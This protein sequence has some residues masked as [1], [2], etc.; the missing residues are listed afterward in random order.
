MGK[1]RK[2]RARRAG[3]GGKPVVAATVERWLQ[4]AAAAEQRGALGEARTYYR[5]VADKVPDHA[6]VWHALAGIC[7]Q[8][9]SPAEAIAALEQACGAEP[10]NSTYLS[11]LGGM[12]MAGGAL[13]EAERTLRAVMS[14]DPELSQARYNFATVLYQQGKIA[15]SITELNRLTRDEPGF[16]EAHFNLA[17][18]LRDIGNLSAALASF[19]AA[20]KLQPENPRVY[21]EIARLQNEAHIVVDAIKHYRRYMAMVD[22]DPVATAEL[23]ELLHRQGETEAAVALLGD[24]PSDG[25]S[26]EQTRLS[27]AGILHNAGQLKEAESVYLSVLGDYP[28][29]TSA[30][31]GLSRLRQFVDP[32]D[33]VILRLRAALNAPGMSETGAEPVHFALGKIYDDLGEYD[34][35]FEHYLRGNTT[36]AM[37][38]NY[39]RA[40]TESFTDDLIGIFSTSALTL[41][42]G[43]TSDSQK[44]VLIVGMP[45]SGTTLTEQIIAS[46]RDAAGAGELAF[47]QA[48]AKQLPELAGTDGAYP[49]CWA[50]VGD[51]TIAEI[52]GQYLGL[53]DRH[54]P[55]SARVTDKM[56]VNY[57]HVGLFHCLFPHARVVVC[58]RD[59]RD[60][61]LSIFF[62][63]FR[64]RHDYAWSLAD[65]AH[66][67]V[68]HER[69][70][71][72][73]LDVIPAV[74]HEINYASLIEDNEPTVR[75]LIDFLNLDW[76][77]GCLKFYEHERDVKTASNWQVRQPVYASS[78][79]RWRHYEAQ[80]AE[81]VQS[82]DTERRRFGLA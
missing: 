61:A 26:Q 64:E 58:R 21:L 45:R 73:W 32:A 27:L 60:I 53:L 62:Q 79:A 10:S 42:R 72:H 38:V 28:R 47:F 57:R 9:D 78:L 44:P 41:P 46:H 48:L 80:L 24:F 8:L 51:G 3:T 65:I 71:R 68:Q 17:V 76:D 23:A 15:E 35:A 49:D 37:S 16:A 43:G 18:A 11:D 19:Q 34:R 70:I 52:C 39:D 7:Y 13:D 2:Q 30:A 77:P 59:P 55:E 74:V 29:A 81:F 69:L 56:P 12:Y 82:L 63:Y 33:P 5:K 75:T 31:V 25:E 20:K 67:Y 66:Y 14:L 40:A 50:K 4:L 1:K 36:H 22:D 6:A 54:G